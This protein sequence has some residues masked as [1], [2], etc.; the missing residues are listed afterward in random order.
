LNT[1]LILIKID[2]YSYNEVVRFLLKR[3]I[4]YKD[5]TLKDNSI[6]LIVK[7]VDLKRIKREITSVKVIKYLGVQGFLLWFKR[8]CVII[9][10]FLFSYI[11]LLTLSN[12]IFDI[13]I[14]TSNQ[15]LKRVISLYLDD[16]NIKKYKFMKSSEELNK[17]KEEILSENKDTLEWIEFERVGTKYTINLT[18]RIVNPK[19]EEKVPSDIVASKDATIL[20]MV[21]KSGTRIKD[22]NEVVKKGEVIISGNIMKD[23]NLVEQ[24]EADGE[25]FGETWYTVTTT[26]P[27]THVE[28]EKTGTTI[29]HIYMNIFGKKI[30]LMGKYETNE[31][32]NTTTVLLDKPYLFFNIMKEQ[33]ELYKYVT[34]NLS[35]EEAYEEAIKRSDKGV[36]DSLDYGEYIIDK[37]V[38]KKNVYSSKIE[39]EIFYKVYENIGEQ[40]ELTPMNIPEGE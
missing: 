38:L 12:V 9:L 39:L 24:V 26:V 20:Y 2:G 15:E 34:H 27:Y 37:K 7:L 3:N 29:N 4:F 31:S 40:R 11:V 25:V 19:N 32:M 5:L 8:H 6:I 33:K 17:I 13:E 23:E 10:S 18:E 36:E 22:L 1:N 14:V 30:T 28:Y 21:T 35:E 16:Y